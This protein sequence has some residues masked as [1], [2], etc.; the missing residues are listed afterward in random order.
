MES[1][2]VR[3]CPLNNITMLILPIYDNNTY[4]QVLIE[5]HLLNQPVRQ[6]SHHMPRF[7]RRGLQIAIVS[8]IDSLLQTIN[9]PPPEGL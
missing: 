2:Y 3:D 8:Y 1:P 5:Y 7:Y 9:N 6:R 4:S